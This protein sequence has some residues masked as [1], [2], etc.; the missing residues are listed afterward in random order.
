MR[1]L[2]D[3]GTS[4][5]SWAFARADVCGNMELNYLANGNYGSLTP[6][7]DCHYNTQL[8]LSTVAAGGY[9]PHGANMTFTWHCSDD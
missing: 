4:V 2:A 7:I 1:P 3:Y 9:D 8:P 5:M 6:L